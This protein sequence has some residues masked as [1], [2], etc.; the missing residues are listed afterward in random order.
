MLVRRGDEVLLARSPQFPKGMYSALA[1]FVEPGET[2]EG[3]I[4]REV[5]EEVGIE[6]G[7]VRYFA[8]QP[9]PFPN[10]LMV[11]FVAEYAG[12]ELNPDPAEIQDAR[13]FAA[14]DLPGIPPPPTIARAMIDA[15]VAEARGLEARTARNVA[16]SLEQG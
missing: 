4:R 8:S 10:S 1:G 15:F 7:E 6:I 3:C 14:D 11:G 13:W 12:G 5:R 2:L 9:W 16:K